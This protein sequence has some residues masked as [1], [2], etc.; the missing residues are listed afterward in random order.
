MVSNGCMKNFRR[1]AYIIYNTL[2]SLA[3]GLGNQLFSILINRFFFPDWWGMIVELQLI[4]YMANA[5]CAWG[6]K[7]FLNRQ[8]GKLPLEA[9]PVWNSLLI[10]RF[11]VLLL[12]VLI[13]LFFVLPLLS[14][15]HVSIW[16]ICRFV[17]QSFDSVI[18]LDKKFKP[19]LFIE[20]FSALILSAG[21]LILFGSLTFNQ[22]LLIITVSN[23]I[24]L[25]AYMLRFSG[26]IQP[27]T[28][29]HISPAL[30]KT[31][32]PFM[33]LAFTGIVQT[34][35]D[36]I[37]IDAW[38]PKSELARYHVYSN[39]LILIRM[40]SAFLLYPF[41]SNLY[42][43]SATKIKPLSRWLL[44]TGIGISSGGLL[45]LSFMMHYVYRMSDEFI[46]YIW[47]FLSCIPGYWFGPVVFYLFKLNKETKVV[48]INILGI[49]V[50]IAVM[51]VTVSLY[52]ISGAL[53]A[54]AIAQLAMGAAY[55]F[56]LIRLL[57]V[58]WPKSA[59]ANKEQNF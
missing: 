34:K 12:P 42:R 32:A 41:I 51:M 52:G 28:W 53:A 45:I 1:V 56:L 8:F 36:L 24:R 17:T 39:F 2:F 7:E 14:F 20:I 10:A 33:L 15:T 16:V 50:N 23:I 21:I 58:P 25:L 46:W 4:Q 31:S 13:M 26:W 48:L 3:P 37:L 6:N 27:V 49:L 19:A 40:G 38:M 11:S 57:S 30:L 44:M 54:T 9:K 5:F 59:V 29:T 35:I 47:G 22:L 18:T 43:L 55:S